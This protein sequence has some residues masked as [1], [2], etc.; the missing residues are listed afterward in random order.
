MRVS[1][2]DKC[3]SNLVV[4]LVSIIEEMLRAHSSYVIGKEAMHQMSRSRVLVSG[5]RGLGVEIA[6]N[7]VLAGVK[8]VTVQ[9]ANHVEYADL[10]SQVPRSLVYAVH[11]TFV[12]LILFS[13]ISMNQILERIER[14][15]LTQN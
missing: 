8:T 4:V 7:I 2:L 9:D 1:I 3:M 15:L 13:T 11:F 14:K 10:S 5:V 12:L 6:K